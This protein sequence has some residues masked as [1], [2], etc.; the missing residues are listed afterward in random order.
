MTNLLENN[1]AIFDLIDPLALRLLRV[2]SSELFD[3]SFQVYSNYYF[4]GF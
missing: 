4:S 3:F 2:F 1:T